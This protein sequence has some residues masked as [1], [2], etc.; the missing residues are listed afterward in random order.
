MLGIIVFL[1]FAILITLLG[2]WG[3]IGW[4]IVALVALVS[5]FAAYILIS[6]LIR[7]LYDSL[8][9]NYFEKKRLRDQIMRRKGLGYEAEDLKS[10][11]K[12]LE[13]KN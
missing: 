3:L 6:R 13:D 2:W 11:L 7:T 9:G 8:L 1:L 4:L 12:S 5:L 10:R